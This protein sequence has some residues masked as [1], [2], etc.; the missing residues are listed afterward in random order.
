MLR[1]ITLMVDN[2]PTCSP[3][4]PSPERLRAGRQVLW[5]ARALAL[6]NRNATAPRG[7]GGY[8]MEVPRLRAETYFGVQARALLVGLHV[9][10][11]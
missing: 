5:Q 4:L 7:V 2:P 11:L 6:A 1:R 8:F 3:N 10:R 9:I